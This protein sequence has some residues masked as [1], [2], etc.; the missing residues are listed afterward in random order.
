MRRYEMN[1]L[2]TGAQFGNKGAQSMLYT[3]INEVRNRYPEADFYYLPLDFFREYCFHSIDDYRFHFV[4]DDQ[5]GQDY[6]AKLGIVNYILRWANIRRIFYGAKKKGEVLLLS[7][8]WDELDVLIDVSGYSLTSKFGIS[9]INRVLRMINTAKAH[10][11]KVILLPQSYGPF[12]FEKVVRKRIRASLSRVDLLFAREEDGIDQLKKYCGVTGAVLSPDIVLQADEVDWRNVFV[13]EPKLQYPHLTTSGNVGIVPNGET[14]RDGAHDHVINTY[15]EILKTLRSNGKE[16]YIFRHSDDLALC[17]EVYELVKEDEH[18]HLIEDEIDCLSYGRF[19]R[20][21][22]FIIASRFHSIVHAYREGV[23]AV[24][25]GW[26]VKYQELT[27]LLGQEQY[28]FDVTDNEQLKTELLIER[29]DRMM[30][31]FDIESEVILSK[32][33]IIRQNSCFDQCKSIL[34]NIV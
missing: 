23:P 7:K 6:P 32:L 27:T 20:Q 4:I 29:L 18:C 5:A 16:V 10:G 30:S 13:H 14:L 24:V 25:L 15:R 9:S 11:L 19:V 31:Q 28:V 26:A 12:C 1:V 21:F 22:D 2:I 33:G 34:D 3:V 8:L 17:R